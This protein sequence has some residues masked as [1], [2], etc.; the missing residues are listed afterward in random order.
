MASNAGKTETWLNG[1]RLKTTS[2]GSHIVIPR[3]AVIVDDIN[4]LVIQSSGTESKSSLL[5]PPLLQAGDRSL[6]LAGRW[7]F[8]IGG[9]E[10]LSNIPLPAK[11]GIGSDVLFEAK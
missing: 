8:R 9:D 4:L 7:Q 3:D 6:K 1:T 11:F 2:D 5:A 10:S